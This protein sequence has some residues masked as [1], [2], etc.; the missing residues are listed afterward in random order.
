[1]V[2]G[3]TILFLPNAIYIFTDLFHLQKNLHA[4]LWYDTILILSYGI[5]GFLYFSHTLRHIIHFFKVNSVSENTL[6]LIQFS[7]IFLSSF[8]VY[9][10]RYLR[11][12]S[13]D[14]F[15][16]PT[17]I[18]YKFNVAV[19]AGQL[20]EIIQVTI[21]FGI[22]IIFLHQIMDRRMRFRQKN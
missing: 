12:N 20:S 14:L 22:F 18:I 5:L 2:L 11:L 15:F 21:F 17:R 19:E 7:I 16:H 10:G 8:G 9:L 3:I 13:W 4:P 1:M 6:K